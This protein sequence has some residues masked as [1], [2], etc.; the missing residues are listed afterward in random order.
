MAQDKK[1]LKKYNVEVSTKDEHMVE[2]ADE[3]LASPTPLWEDFVV[4][5]FL[6]RVPHVAKVHMVLNKI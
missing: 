1:M 2:I 6:D 3:I 4:G 5:K